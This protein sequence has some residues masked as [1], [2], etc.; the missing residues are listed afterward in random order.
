MCSCSRIRAAR[1]CSSS[2]SSTGTVFCRMIG[3]VVE[4]FVHEVD[5]AAGNLHTVSK[6]L[7]LGLKPGKRRQQR[8]MNVKDAPRKLLH[9]PRRKQPHVS[10]KTHQ[11]NFVFLRSAAT[12]SRSCSA[13]SLF[14]D[15]ITSAVSPSRRAVSI[16]PASSRLE[17]TTA[18]RASGIRPAATFLAMASKFEPRPESR[19]PRF[20]MRFLCR[21]PSAFGASV[22]HNSTCA[23]ACRFATVPSGPI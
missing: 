12:T 5:R 23:P 15:G 21:Q 17:I 1:V 7:L 22:Y 4:F 16:P 10:R 3:A 18:M 8:W 6:S 2:V 14:L 19:M 20:F 9:E 13:R 11:V